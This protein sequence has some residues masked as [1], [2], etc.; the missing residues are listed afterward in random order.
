MNQ[1]K[2]GEETR[3]AHFAST[4]AFTL[5]RLFKLGILAAFLNDSSA[6]AIAPNKVLRVDLEKRFEPLT[7]ADL[8]LEEIQS[9]V[10]ISSKLKLPGYHEVRNRLHHSVHKSRMEA[11][12]KRGGELDRKS[13]QKFFETFSKTAKEE[14]SVRVPM[15][16]RE[17]SS[18][19]GYLYLGSP[20]S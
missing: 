7:D 15:I 3:C 11:E 8:A 19:S 1:T 20:V 14:T 17:D 6:I 4:K 5:Q 10:Q 16:N 13:H 2:K 9:H 12:K 18:Y